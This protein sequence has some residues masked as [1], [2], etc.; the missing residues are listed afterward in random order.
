MDRKHRA[1]KRLLTFALSVAL[2]VTFIPTSL[3]VYAADDDATGAA[4]VEKSV[5]DDAAKDAQ[6]SDS[7]SEDTSKEITPAKEEPASKEEAK[8]EE[9]SK[10][11]P[12]SV[13]LVPVG[14]PKHHVTYNGKEQVLKHT[15]ENPLYKFEYYIGGR[16]VSASEFPEGFTA[17][18]YTVPIK[19]GEKADDEAEL[20]GTNVGMRC[21]GLR[22]SLTGSAPG[23]YI[24][25]PEQGFNLYFYI[26]PLDVDV[27]ITGKTEEITY[28][29][30][31]HVL[32]MFEPSCDNDLYDFRDLGISSKPPTARNVGEHTTGTS[33]RGY[34]ENT[35]ENFNVDFSFVPGKLTIKP[36]PLTI[37]T[38]SDRT[39]VEPN[40]PKV[41][42]CPKT[43]IEG[44]VGQDE[45]AG[46]RSCVANGKIAINKVGAVE[47]TLAEIDW[48]AVDPNNYE[49]TY[50]LGTLTVFA[51]DE[52]QI[53]IIGAGYDDK[54]I[55][56]DC[57]THSVDGYSVEGI[58]NPNFEYVYKM[59]GADMIRYSGTA[60]AEGTDAGHYAMN[61]DADKFSINPAVDE[62]RD[63]KVTFVITDGGLTIKQRPL[64][65]DIWP[66]NETHTYTGKEISMRAFN[67]GYRGSLEE[68]GYRADDAIGFDG[69]TVIKGTD[70]GK[71]TETLTLDKFQ[72][73][74][75]N[76]DV[77]F[78]LTDGIL[79]PIPHRG[80]TE[81]ITEFTSTLEIVRPV[82]IVE[83]DA[84]NY[85][86]D[87]DGKEHTLKVDAASNKALFDGVVQEGNAFTVK[88]VINESNVPFDE[89][90]IY[91][92]SDINLSG[93][94][95]GTYMERAWAKRLSYDDPGITV[96]FVALSSMALR[97]NPKQLTLKVDDVEITYEGKRIDE[98]RDKL[99]AHYE[100]LSEGE[101]GPEYELS[102]KGWPDEDV[103]VTVFESY[104][105]GA[106]ILSDSENYDITVEPGTFTV[107]KRPVTVTVAGR[108][109]MAPYV[110]RDGI[111][112]TQAVRGYDI[113]CDD[114]LY[115]CDWAIEV[116]LKTEPYAERAEVG[117]TNM[118]LNSSNVNF[119]N[120][121]NAFDVTLNVVDGYIK[122]V[123]SD[124][125]RINIGTVD[126]EGGKYTY[127][128]EHH[129][130][131]L[132]KDTVTVGEK[133]YS[134][135]AR[136][137]RCQPVGGGHF[138][139]ED[140]G[141]VD[142]GEYTAELGNLR[143]FDG[144]VDV[145]SLCNFTKG[146]PVSIIIDPKPIIVEVTGQNLK[147]TWNPEF[148][149]P[150][151]C[152]WS[153]N[154]KVLEYDTG[155]PCSTYYPQGLDSHFLTY[156]DR[157]SWP[158]FRVTGIGTYPYGIKKSEFTNNN[159]NYV[160]K[161]YVITDGCYE[162]VGED[163]MFT[164]QDPTPVNEEFDY[165]G[166]TYHAINR[167]FEELKDGVFELVGSDGHTYYMKP[168]Y[169]LSFA[170]ELYKDA[171]VYTWYRTIST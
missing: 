107:L 100:G 143:V 59:N 129:R 47:N 54:A 23:Y 68:V 12:V 58:D 158:T 8:E 37:E 13:N 29:G 127:D 132:K 15:S 103:P 60:H 34:I 86:V 28:D 126:L 121:D 144:D 152:H 119:I 39:M 80:K 57:K 17:D 40:S 50:K 53:E 44:L 125:E 84:S 117:Q 133:T 19:K 109:A 73:L 154:I 110:E 63:F 74:D 155:E 6:K 139:D 52:V 141:P 43:W 101:T 128:G 16:Q 113:S 42:T 25:Q 64:T 66:N 18:I 137:I 27:T 135:E 148:D 123:P 61:L 151:D 106:S 116:A 14:D 45:L 98:Y 157:E 70:V 51:E 24:D 142:A 9:L 41:F 11:A 147:S 95:T 10:D 49:I 65:V 88:S 105:I 62:A 131:T 159:S 83:L 162:F 30:E 79:S 161:D 170:G 69:D 78:N 91:L 35:N 163:A 22:A 7:V 5:T 56:Y 75:K 102:F 146:D 124:T 71:Y 112:W 26:D 85:R 87:Y 145:T 130:A 94:D 166:V 169:N 4:V 156:A 165:D 136:D 164:I 76:Y 31:P 160:V 122:I 93:T 120:H 33:L 150:F 89:S 115:N 48:G 104:D 97:V 167:N 77:T 108:K 81:A 3:F 55:T 149:T 72:N 171:G 96:E 111:P 21:V 99:T 140:L 92:R 138:V 118:G 38:A 134:L 36:A 2:T 67:W 1:M 32:D 153:V 82:V 90:K 168:R 114:E 46:V 20:R